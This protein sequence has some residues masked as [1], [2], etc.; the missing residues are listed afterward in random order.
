MMMKIVRH[1][2]WDDPTEYIPAFFTT[3]TI[4][5]A[6]SISAGIAVGF[7]SYAFAKTVTR[8][9]NECHWLIYFFAVLFALQFL[10]IG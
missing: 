2:P 9:W 7:I 3:V 5:F 10:L 8:R 4:C 1:L 6:F